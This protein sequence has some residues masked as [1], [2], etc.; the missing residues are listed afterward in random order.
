MPVPETLPETLPEAPEIDDLLAGAVTA[1]DVPYVLGGLTDR[2]GRVRLFAHGTDP[3]TGRPVGPDTLFWIASMTKAL[4][5]VAAMQLEVQDRL[6]LDAPIGALLPRLARRDIL[7]GF[8]D[9]GRPVLRPAE[10]PITLRHLLSHSSGFAEGVWHAGI[11]RWH[12]ATG[13]P[14]VGTGRL[15]G[16]DLPLVFEPGSAW[17]Y[18]VSHD[19]VGQAVEAASG[20]RLD[21]YFAACLFGPLGMRD[22]VHVPDPGQAGRLLSLHRRD[23]D[24]TLTPM[25]RPP[26]PPDREFFSGSGTMFSTAPDYLAFVAML[27]GDGSL[28]ATHILPPG[29]VA[30][31]AGEHTGD[32][33]VGWLD[34][35]MPDGSNRVEFLPGR[36][37]AWGLGMLVTLEDLPGRRRSGS[38]SWGGLGNT[39]FWADPATGLGGVL[40][41][42]ILPFADPRTLALSD[43]F[44]AACYGRYG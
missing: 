28:G 29:T 31:M 36:R 4:T 30:R 13:H 33:A 26:P 35:A 12:E 41:T 44:E 15:A 9:A 3:G 14:Q 42:Q 10:R 19:W 17:H 5:S 1:G 7:E 34:P 24:G 11:L 40:L 27:L 37:K 22:T 43:A 25:D 23:A 20:L 39:Y 38:L 2:R 8:D 21:R 6:D 18:G 16:L 32:M